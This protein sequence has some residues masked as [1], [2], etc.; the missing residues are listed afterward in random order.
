ML[1]QLKL[2]QKL[3]LL[4]LS[5]GGIGVGTMLLLLVLADHQV[6][7]RYLPEN[8]A[9]RDIE[10][11]SRLLVQNYYRYM[12][13]PEQITVDE[14]V[15][16]TILIRQRI[17]EYRQ[18]VDAQPQKLGLAN[19]IADSTHRLEE[20]GQ[21]LILARQRF[22]Q[23]DELQRDL[24]REVERV[25]ARYKEAVSTDIRSSIANE[26]WAPFTNRYFPELRMIKTLHLLYLQLFHEIRVSQITVDAD[27][28][29]LISQRIKRIKDSSALLEL[30]EENEHKR[31]WLATNILVIYEKMTD[32]VNQF[33][34]AKR[35]AEFALS[36]AEQAGIDLNQAIGD[37][38]RSSESVGWQEL[39][40]SLL[41]SA[42]VLLATLMISY[43]LIYAGLDRILRPLEKLQTVITRLGKGDFKQRSRDVGRN[44]EIGQLASAFNRMADQL[45][46][47]SRQKQQFI[48][49]LEQKNMELERFTYTVSHE[50]KSPLVTVNGF[51]GLL[52]RDLEEQHSERVARD[53]QQIE[54]A[55]GT[56]SRQL[57]DLLELSRVGHVV[58]PPQIFDFNTVC[59]EAVGN[60]QGAVSES[61]AQVEIEENEFDIHADRE[62]VMEIFQ[63]LIENAIKFS[64]PLGKPHVVISAEPVGDMLRCRV[65]DNG[66]GID[67]QYHDKVFELFDRLDN[68]VP[69]T[70]IGLALVKRIVEIHG[71]AIWIEPNDGRTGVSFVFDLPATELPQSTA[72]MVGNL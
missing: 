68:S 69:G 1:S 54:S 26:D 32:I 28:D 49:Q 7:D 62:R 13:T 67:P 48:E 18:L 5:V 52:S 17:D 43:L 19:A 21:N 22:E 42:M 2:R 44:D 29:Q 46:E 31:S 6:F 30:Y 8:R 59:R 20:A 64:S 11:R 16:G 9:L 71:G 63:N 53:M 57:E 55:V 40:R 41:L 14:V 12:L 3:L 56:M 50:L 58:S 23:A 47:S 37:S 51:L 15:N 24:E 65:C 39:R 60:L 27:N 33:R 45:E 34:E 72:D 10:A 70:G 4:L 61:G 35:A 38:I 66:P 25:F 36:T